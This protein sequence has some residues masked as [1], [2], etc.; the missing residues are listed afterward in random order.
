M[1]VQVA[2]AAILSVLEIDKRYYG[3]METILEKPRNNQLMIWFY[4]NN[5][6]QWRGYDCITLKKC[7]E[8]IKPFS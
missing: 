5:D 3:F 1:V 7:Y 6:E 4:R 2:E 8:V